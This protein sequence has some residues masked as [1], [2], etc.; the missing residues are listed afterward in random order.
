[1]VKQCT[2]PKEGV[3][4][5]VIV[6][7]EPTK[8]PRRGLLERYRN[9]DAEEISDV[10]NVPISEGKVN[11]QEVMVMRDTGFGFRLFVLV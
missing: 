1:M 4:A 8:V 3:S 11:G 7:D 2:K 6:R 5:A 10:L 9:L